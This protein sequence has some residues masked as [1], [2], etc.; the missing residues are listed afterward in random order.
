VDGRD[1][2]RAV[3]L[4]DVAAQG[5]EEALAAA[6]LAPFRDEIG[7]AR[8]L[9]VVASGAARAIDVH[10]LPWDGAPL[11]ARLPVVYP[12][13]HA[14]AADPGD[15][16]AGAMRALVVG[17]PTSDL[18]RA[19]AEI[20]GVSRALAGSGSWRV[21]VLRR[22]DATGSRVR[23]EL[24]DAT[25]FH[26]AGHG[27]Y[28][29]RDGWESALPLAD[30]GELTVADVLALPRAPRRVVLLGCETARSSADAAEGG[31]GLGLAQAFLVAGAEEAVAATRDVDDAVAGAIAEGLYAGDAPRRGLDESLRAAQIAAW[32]AGTAGWSALRVLVR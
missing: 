9:A 29:G 22:R 4:G 28:A 26:Y 8:R 10:A 24:S 19:R 1:R 32:R 16:D 2:T 5:T 27:R 31:A 3:E 20:D 18:E 25:L 13:D 7:R 21:R 23:Q 14:A 30:H 12:I 15:G 11:V 17:D 6:L